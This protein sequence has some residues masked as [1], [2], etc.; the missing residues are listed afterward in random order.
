MALG[1][2]DEM[3]LRIAWHIRQYVVDKIRL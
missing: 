3:A 2:S 1:L